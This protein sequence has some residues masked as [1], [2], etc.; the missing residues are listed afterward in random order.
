MDLGIGGR[1]ALVTAASQ[2]LGK[3]IAAALAAEGARVAITSRSAERCAAAAAEIGA[4]ASYAHDTGDVDGA[5]GL[6]ERV[7]ADLGPIDILVTNVGGPPAGPDALAFT[8]EQWRAAY[9][10]LMLGPL[11]L[12]E[13]VVPG[14]RDRGWGRILGSS[15]NV[16]REPIGQLMLS[17]SHR[18]GLLA[19]F[20]IL[21]RQLAPDGITVNSLLPGRIRTKRLLEIYG[22][23]EAIEKMVRSDIPAGRL[24]TVE[25]YAAAAA[26]LCSAPA[27]YITGVALLIDGGMTRAI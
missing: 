12:I 27:A 7:A 23:E 9:R 22:S 15:S 14:M 10:D 2:G 4:A 6:V 1:V 25:E 18:T 26:F 3:A 11:A 5:A 17:T 16:V 8:R 19:A 21:S 13:A 24:G 20:K